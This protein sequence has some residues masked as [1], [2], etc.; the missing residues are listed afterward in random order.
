MNPFEMP[1]TGK[2]ADWLIFGVMLLAI[3]LPVGAFVI[4]WTVFRKNSQRQRRKRRQRHR[5]Q[6]NPTLAETGGLPP[7]RDPNQPPAGL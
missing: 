4:W 2:S 3:G 7:R 5:R 1:T 6:R